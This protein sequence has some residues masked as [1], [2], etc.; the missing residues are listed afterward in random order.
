MIPEAYQDLLLSAQQFGLSRNVIGVHYPTDIIGGR[1]VAYYTMAQA[2]A[3]DPS[4]VAG[5]YPALLQSTASVLR[6]SIAGG[7]AHTLCQLRDQ[8]RG[9]Y[10][11]RNLPDGGAIHRRQPVLCRADQLRAARDR[12]D[13]PR[14]GRPG[15]C[16]PADRRALPLSL[17][18]QLSDVLASTELASGAPL[19]NGSGWARLN[20]YAAAGGYGAFT[21]NVT[22]TMNA[23]QGGFNAI[24]LWSN[25]ISGPGGL[26]KLGTG[27]LVL[28]GNNT[29]T[30]A[31]SS[32]AAP[33]RSAAP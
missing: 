12:S 5:N 19:D 23:A 31:P 17:G 21:S 32:V 7:G 15:Q 11:Q 28:G 14:A 27:T 18:S 9:V 26:T 29:Y 10:R 6:G 24:D 4:F 3:N 2:L 25:N 1:I 8:R 30:A 22:V 33:W 13:Q 20:L 16:Q